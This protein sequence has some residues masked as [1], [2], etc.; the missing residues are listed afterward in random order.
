MTIM[1]QLQVSDEI[2]RHNEEE[3]ARFN[4]LMEYANSIEYYC[5]SP[6]RMDKEY[7]DYLCRYF[8]RNVDSCDGMDYAHRMRSLPMPYN[9]YFCG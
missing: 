1:K 2:R 9:I 5:M 3:M 7:G 8:D 4:K 6:Y